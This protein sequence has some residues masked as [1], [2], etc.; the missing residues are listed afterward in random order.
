MRINITLT[1]CHIAERDWMNAT[2]NSNINAEENQPEDEQM[3]GTE[4]QQ[5][6]RYN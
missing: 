6:I 3:N 4:I 5:E 2:R 1:F